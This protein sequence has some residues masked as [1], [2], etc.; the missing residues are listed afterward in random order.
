M[1]ATKSDDSLTDFGLHLKADKIGF[2]DLR[3]VPFFT[4]KTCGKWNTYFLSLYSSAI[5][6]LKIDFFQKFFAL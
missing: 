4:S 6:S 2:L 5:F 3:F 1:G